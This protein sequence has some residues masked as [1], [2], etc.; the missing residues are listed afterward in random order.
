VEKYGRDRQAT[1]VIITR[2][3]HIACWIA[4]ATDAHPESVIIIIR[5]N[6]INYQTKEGNVIPV[7]AMNT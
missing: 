4:K 6:E 5:H 1:D 7:L 3:M 2:R